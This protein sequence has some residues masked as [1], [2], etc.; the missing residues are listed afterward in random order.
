MAIPRKGSRKI[1]VEGEDYRWLV[2]R[3]ATISQTDYGSGKIHVAIEHATEKGATLHIES[4][5]HPHPKDWGTLSV[6][7]VTPSDIARWISVAIQQGWEPKNAGP[8]FR[9]DEK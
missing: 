5:R 6:E 4:G 9:I 3:K 2:R 8:T 7:P 1:T